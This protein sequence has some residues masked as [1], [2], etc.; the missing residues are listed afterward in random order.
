MQVVFR[1]P[2]SAS[3]LAVN[4]ILIYLPSSTFFER[5]VVLLC[6]LSNPSVTGPLLAGAT[7]SWNQVSLLFISRP[8]GRDVSAQYTP[9]IIFGC[10]KVEYTLPKA[11]RS[12][13]QKRG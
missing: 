9:S 2:I 8:S 10:K 1:F 4:S 13:A 6:T 5:I 11:E 7:S 12:F 3:F